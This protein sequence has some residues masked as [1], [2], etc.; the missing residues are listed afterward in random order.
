MSEPL[1]HQPAPAADEPL[2]LEPSHDHAIAGHRYDGIR[3]YDN[4]M[5]RWWVMLF[6]I[7]IIWS[8]LYVLGVHVFDWIP[9]YGERLAEQTAQLE[10]TRTAYAAANPT[11]STE[12][13]ALAEY[14]ANADHAAAGAAVFATTCVACHG[15]KGQGGIGPNLTDDYW[16]HGNAPEQIF[17][18]ITKGVLEKGMPPQETALTDEQ[19]G[20]LVAFIESI[21]G[22]NPPGAKEPQGDKVAG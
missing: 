1:E 20:Q 7:T 21:H 2:P 14:A 12:P 17:H 3:E 10:E 19:R 16:I 9:T 11:F 13:A 4:P 8:P 18:T 6:W 5:P 22:S 15:D